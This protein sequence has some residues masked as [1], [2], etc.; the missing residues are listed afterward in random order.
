M[1][2][3]RLDIITGSKI[4]RDERGNVVSNEAAVHPSLSSC[5]WRTVSLAT[6]VSTD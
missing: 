5:H 4:V 2:Q 1:K 3:C 6:L